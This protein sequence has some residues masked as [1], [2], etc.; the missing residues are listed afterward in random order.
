[1]KK[2][3]RIFVAPSTNEK[4]RIR[5]VPST[6]MMSVLVSAFKELDIS[7]EKWN[8][9]DEEYRQAISLGIVYKSLDYLVGKRWVRVHGRS[10]MQ[11]GY[12][13]MIRQAKVFGLDKKLKEDKGLM[14]RNIILN[15]IAPR[16]I[17]DKLPLWASVLEH[18]EMGAMMEDGFNP[19]TAALR[20]AMSGD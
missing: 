19:I 6:V 3:D 16:G 14:L 15:W 9:G 10:Q 5:S 2:Q 20:A 18:S 7:E 13:A 8:S 11:R 17:D 4:L 12:E 1:M